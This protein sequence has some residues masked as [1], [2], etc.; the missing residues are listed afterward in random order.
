MPNGTLEKWIPSHNFFLDML[1]RIDIMIDVASA[2]DHLHNGYS[3]FVVHCDLKP[4]NGLLDQEMIG[5]VSDFAIAKLLGAGGDFVETKTIATIGYTAPEYGQ[6][7]IVST[8]CDI[9][10]LWHPNDGDVYKKETR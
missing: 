6:D 10:S 2:M 9:Y 4:S 8:S 7:G 3:T 1:Q 5:H